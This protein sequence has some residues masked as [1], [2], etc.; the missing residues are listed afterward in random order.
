MLRH[1]NDDE[2][3][4]EPTIEGIEYKIN[5][6]FYEKHEQKIKKIKES[7]TKNLAVD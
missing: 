2:V 4:F 3:D 6:N 5:K 1:A 7:S